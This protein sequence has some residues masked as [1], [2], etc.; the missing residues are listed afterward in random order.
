V[1]SHLRLTRR[2]IYHPHQPHI[3]VGRA[4]LEELADS[5]AA[6]SVPSAAAAA[7]PAMVA[8]LDLIWSNLIAHIEENSF[9]KHDLT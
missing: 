5:E 9:I 1:V 8:L 7:I 3:P 4:A 6:L 2:A